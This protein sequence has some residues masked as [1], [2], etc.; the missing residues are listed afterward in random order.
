MYGMFKSFKDPCDQD[1]KRDCMMGEILHHCASKISKY[2]IC[3]YN[4]VDQSSQNFR[5][6]M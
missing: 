6:S 5:K 1:S 3:H 2:P 4:C